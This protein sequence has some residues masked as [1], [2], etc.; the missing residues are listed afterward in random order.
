MSVNILNYMEQ[1]CN[2][3]SSEQKENKQKSLIEQDMRKFICSIISTI[4]IVSVIYGFAIASYIFN[5]NECYFKNTYEYIFVFKIISGIFIFTCSFFSTMDKY[6]NSKILPIIFTIIYIYEIISLGF[7]ILF[8]K[9]E[10]N[11]GK[12]FTGM[13]FYVLAVSIS[14]KCIN[15][16]FKNICCQIN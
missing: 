1:E 7:L 3:F 11:P 16:M 10:N 13:F 8:P 14:T 15:N 12:F 5:K 4:F 6:K 9:C 2:Q